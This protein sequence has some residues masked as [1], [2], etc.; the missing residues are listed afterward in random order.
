MS[1][2]RAA[3]LAAIAAAYAIVMR[4]RAAA[5]SPALAPPAWR[6]AARIELATAPEARTAARRSAWRASTAP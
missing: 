6:L 5:S 2:E 1:D 3:E 4:A